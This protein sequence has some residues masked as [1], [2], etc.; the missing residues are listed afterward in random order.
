MLVDRYGSSLY[1]FDVIDTGTLVV[2]KSE[3][4]TMTGTVTLPKAPTGTAIFLGNVWGRAGTPYLQPVNVVGFVSDS[5]LTINVYGTSFVSGQGL[6][7]RY[8]VLDK[9]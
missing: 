4:N 3:G 7:V 5:T 6:E 8:I 2:R 9:H 1:G